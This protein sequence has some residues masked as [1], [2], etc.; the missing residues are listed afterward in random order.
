M[1]RVSETHL[2]ARRQQILD[3]ARTC[4]LR[5]GFHQTSMHDVTAEAGLSI[6]AVYRYFPSKAEI[7][8]AIAGQYATQIGAELA[9]LAGQDRPV[10]DVMEAAIG[11][12]DRATGPDGPMRLAVQ[13]WSEALRDERIGATAR[14]VYTRFRG[15]FVALAERAV[16][17]GEL[18][19]GTDP[20]AVGAALFSLVIGYTLQKMLTGSPARDTYRRGVRTL[21]RAGK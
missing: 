15:T 5:N 21:L 4:F 19:A 3:A 17:T 2:A 12:V 1:P 13:V 16:A 20:R 14:T 8:E 18:P 6:G 10:V 9:G 7:V 11:I